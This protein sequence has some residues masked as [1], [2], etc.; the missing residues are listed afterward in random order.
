[1]FKT[2]A[3]KDAYLV[4]PWPTESTERQATLTVLKKMYNI[5]TEDRRQFTTTPR[6]IKM[7]SIRILGIDS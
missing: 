3:G 6:F 5:S 1:M 7:V 4:D 2:L